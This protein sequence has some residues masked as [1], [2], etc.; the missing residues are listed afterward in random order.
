M[1][2]DQLR[3]ERCV[4]RGARISSGKEACVSLTVAMPLGA[5]YGNIAK[6]IASLIETSAVLDLTVN[7]TEVQP[8]LT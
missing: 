4:I 8:E 7:V 6:T 5:A 1:P 3:I 2:P